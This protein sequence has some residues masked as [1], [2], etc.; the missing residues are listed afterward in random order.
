MEDKYKRFLMSA[1]DTD[2]KHSQCVTCKNA[3]DGFNCKVYG[4]KPEKYQFEYLKTECP[5]RIEK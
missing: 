5:V 3:I 2:V 4:K 1:G